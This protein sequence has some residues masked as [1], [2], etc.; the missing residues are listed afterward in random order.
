MGAKR[1]S[2]EC[3]GTSGLDRLLCL[4]VKRYTRIS[5][6]QTAL[7]ESMISTSR[8]LPPVGILLSLETHEFASASFHLCE[9]D[10]HS[11]GTAETPPATS[12]LRNISLLSLREYFRAVDLANMLLEILLPWHNGALE[13]KLNAGIIKSILLA[14]IHLDEQ[15]LVLVDQGLLVF[16]DVDTT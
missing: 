14:H 9:I 15:H 4:R 11:Q 8:A 5:Q 2:S 13:S 16:A 12:W 1:V 10:N 6:H 7:I 3:K